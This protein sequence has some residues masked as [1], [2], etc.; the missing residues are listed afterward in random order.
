MFGSWVEM[1]FDWLIFLINSFNCLTVGSRLLIFA[2]SAYKFCGF[3]LHL[4]IPLTFCGIH[5]QLRNSKQLAIFACCGFRGTT[6]VPT[7]FMLQVFVRG[8]HRSFV[9]GIH[10]FFGTSLKVCLWNPGTCRHKTVRLSSAQFGLVM[11]VGVNYLTL[12]PKFF[13]QIQ[14]L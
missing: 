11:I 8:I 14:N 4:R 9:S 10:W 3:H 7:E 6:N 12:L 1:R 5:L 13:P 2:D